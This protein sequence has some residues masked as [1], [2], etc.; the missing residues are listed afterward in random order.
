LPVP[1][2]IRARRDS[3]K[4]SGGSIF[5]VLIGVWFGRG[6]PFAVDH[7]FALHQHK[8]FDINIAGPGDALRITA[9]FFSKRAHRASAKMTRQRLDW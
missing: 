5:G 8:R 7:R 4:C 3:F 1:A 2:N 9:P 6:K